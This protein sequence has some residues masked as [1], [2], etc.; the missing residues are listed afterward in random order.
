MFTEI[1]RLFKSLAIFAP[2]PSTNQRLV[3]KGEFKV[4]PSTPN[5]LNNNWVHSYGRTAI[6]ERS[7]REMKELNRF[8]FAQLI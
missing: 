3:V 8:K 7:K 2:P 4:V 1:I 5:P 6:K